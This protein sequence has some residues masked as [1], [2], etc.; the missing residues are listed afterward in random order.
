VTKAAPPDI[1]TE[2]TRADPSLGRAIDAVIARTGRQRIVSSRATPFEALVRAVVYQSISGNAAGVI[3]SRL[4]QIVG[5][6]FGPAK[7]LAVP[8]ITLLTTGLSKTKTNA[9]RSL[10]EWFT[11]NWQMAKT[12]PELPDEDVIRALTGIA[13]VGAWTVNVFLIFNLGRL[14]VLP[15][16][17]LGIRRGVQL[18][19]DLEKIA[20]PK[21]VHEKAEFWRPHRSIAS[22]YLW[23]AVRLKLGP[24]DLNGRQ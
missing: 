10:A 7:I 18:I 17:D 20:T 2:L 21:M 5:G 11:A 19:Y 6:A 16:A 8:Q 15:A 1:E 23:N 14:D 22:M 12:L 13:G 9:I 4:K 3:F 24:G